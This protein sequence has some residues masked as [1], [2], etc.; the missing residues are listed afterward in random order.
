[1]MS[2]ATHDSNGDGIPPFLYGTHYSTVS[3]VL[4]FSK[5]MTTEYN[6]FG[7]IARI[8]TALF[9]EGCTRVYAVLAKR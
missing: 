7:F 8:R 4:S 1:M 6:N 2:S 9:S 3:T 5:Q